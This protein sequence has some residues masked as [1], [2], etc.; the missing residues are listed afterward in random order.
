M[1]Q[2]RKYG[3]K[4][5]LISIMVFLVLGGSVF[6]FYL[7]QKVQYQRKLDILT[8]LTPQ[9]VTLFRIYPRVIIPSGTPVEFR[10]SNPLIQEFLQALTDLKTYWP[11]HD[12]VNSR[13][14]SWFLEIAGNGEVVQIHCYIPSDKEGIVVGEIGRFRQNSGTSYD[15]FQSRNVFQWYQKY[16]NEWLTAVSED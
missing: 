8:S 11:S 5:K 9:Q 4:Q 1:Q 15:H 16:N 7:Y 6:G 13:D 3:M 14:H 12:R 10:V 2:S